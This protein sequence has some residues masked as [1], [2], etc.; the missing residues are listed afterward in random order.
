MID[1]RHLLKLGALGGVVI[2][3]GPALAALA[4]P[5]EPGRKPAGPDEAFLWL[6]HPD[7]R[8]AAARLLHD[9]AFV[10]ASA[11]T[12]AALRGA[13]ATRVPQPRTDM[14]TQRRT[15]PGSPGQPDVSI[16]IVN[17]RADAVR[18]AILH[19]H[20]GGFVAGSAAQGLADLQE[21]CTQLDCVAV[22]VDYRLAPETRWSG[23]CEDTYA[24]LKWLHDHAFELGA[25]PG[26]IAVM[27]ESAGGGHAALLAI[28]ARDRGEVPVAFQCLTY[29]MLDDRTVTRKFLPH[30]GRLI[31]T[32]ASNRFGWQSF[33]GVPPGGKAVPAAVPARQAD[34]AGLPPAFIGVGALDLFFDEDLDYAQ[35]LTVAGVPAQLEAVPGAFHGFDLIVPK[36]GISTRFRAARIDALRRGLAPVMA[37]HPDDSSQ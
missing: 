26:R 31:W 20:G 27:G 30:V 8:E 10:T 9:P 3:C 13:M 14:P 19:M 28:L 16:L 17:A 37:P 32:P 22:S 29:P 35:R 1:R 36:A 21:I 4:N 11:G 24:A 23:S 7:L 15:I 34:L 6:V 2:P 18:P 12:L 25:H 5:A 33:L